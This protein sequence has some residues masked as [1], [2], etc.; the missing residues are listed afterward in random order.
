ML[1]KLFT[2]LSASL[3]LLLVLTA[4]PAFAANGPGPGGVG[5][6]IHDYRY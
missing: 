2:S 1:K 6:L 4:I 5:Y 3:C